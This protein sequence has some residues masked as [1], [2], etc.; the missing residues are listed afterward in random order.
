MPTYLYKCSTENCKNYPEFEEFH[1]ISSK[2]DNCP[3]CGSEVTR[4]IN[5]EGGA[6]VELFGQDFVDKIKSDAKKLKKEVHSNENTM[7][8]LVGENKF[9]SIVK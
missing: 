8:N 2:L 4:L 7:A 6:K 5:C 9:N 3:Q 1:S